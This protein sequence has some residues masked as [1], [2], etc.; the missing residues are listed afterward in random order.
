MVTRLAVVVLA[1]AVAIMARQMWVH[2]MFSPWTSAEQRYLDELHAI[3]DA[4]WHGSDAQMVATGHDMCERLRQGK[5]QAAPT[6][7]RS[8]PRR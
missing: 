5:A 6:A 2:D 4:P 1:V 3:H 8:T 7:W